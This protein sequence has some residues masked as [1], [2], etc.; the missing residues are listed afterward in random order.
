MKSYE[1]RVIRL[2]ETPDA[3]KLESPEAAYHY[4]QS[5]ITK[6]PWFIPDREICVTITLNT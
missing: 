5:V 4:W 1:I 3:P 2:N 6:M